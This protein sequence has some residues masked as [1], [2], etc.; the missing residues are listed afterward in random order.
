MATVLVSA[1]AEGTDEINQY[2]NGRYV[3]APEAV[4]STQQLPVHE[5]GKAFQ[6]LGA[7]G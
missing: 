1:D 7:V 2:L 5:S 4:P 6:V 3:S